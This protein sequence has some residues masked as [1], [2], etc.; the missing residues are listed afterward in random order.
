M[1]EASGATRTGGRAAVMADVGRVA[2]VSHMTVS[3]VINDHPSVRPE[4]R[5]RVLAAMNELDYRPNSAARALV[6][7]KS[8]TLGVVSIDTTL[9]GPAS[10]LYGIEQAARVAGYFVSIVSLQAL[11]RR[12]VGDAVERLRSQAVEGIVIIAP[13]VSAARALRYLPKDMPAVAVEGGTG[14]LPIV[15]VDQYAGAVRATGHLLSLGHRTVWHIAGPA[16]WLEAQARERGWRETL[17]ES[18]CVVPAVLRG[19]WSARS[20]YELGK[21]LAGEH[22]V[23]AVFV[24]NDQMALGLLRALHEAGIE[25]PGR[26]SVVGFDDVPESA[27]FTPP[28]TT[29]RQD[30]GEVGRRSLELLLSL[31]GGTEPASRRV[32]VEPQLIVRDSAAAAS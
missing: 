23:T 2:G 20:G 11:T 19:D 12:S 22:E 31:V 15:A 24:A 26:V 18:G 1:T 9:Y 3:R 8:G 14:P 10:T 7:G 16:D 28:L 27:Y 29:V 6:T 30:F 21:R 5:M 25:V 32:V 17:A 13:H 4:T